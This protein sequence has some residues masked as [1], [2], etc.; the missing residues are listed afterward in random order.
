MDERRWLHLTHRNVYPLHNV[1]SA[2][3]FLYPFFIGV[4]LLVFSWRWYGRWCCNPS[5]FLQNFRF[6]VTG[7]PSDERHC[8]GDKPTI[9]IN[10]Q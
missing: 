2:V 3:V 7:V 10:F 4:R 5:F 9:Q 1:Q 8:S 6:R